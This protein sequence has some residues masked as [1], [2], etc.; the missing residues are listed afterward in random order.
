VPAR[1]MD[2]LFR[3]ILRD[4]RLVVVPA[5]RCNITTKKWAAGYAR[6]LRAGKTTARI[7]PDALQAMLDELQGLRRAALK[8]PLSM[9]LL[10]EQR[11]YA[12]V[13]IALVRDPEWRAAWA[14]LLTQ[15]AHPRAWRC[16]LGGRSALASATMS[17][18]VLAPAE[19]APRSRAAASNGGSA[20]AAT[21]AAAAGGGVVA[22]P[23]AGV[24]AAAAGG[25]GTAAAAGP[26]TEFSLSS[27]P[28]VRCSLDSRLCCFPHAYSPP[29]FV[30]VPG[31]VFLE[32]ALILF[33]TVHSDT[34]IAAK[35]C[36]WDAT[37][38]RKANTLLQTAIGTLT[39]LRDIILREHT[40]FGNDLTSP[41]LTTLLHLLSAQC[42]ECILLETAHLAPSP[43]QPVVG[44]AARARLAAYVSAE[45]EAARMGISD[46]VQPGLCWER[47]WSTIV[48][49]KQIIFSVLAH[50]CQ[51]AHL[52][53][54]HVL[55]GVRAH[56]AAAASKL[57][58]LPSS[59]LPD[60][61]Q[62]IVT[63][64]SSLAR[65]HHS[66]CEREWTAVYSAALTT[67][68]ARYDPVISLYIPVRPNLDEALDLWQQPLRRA[69]SAWARI[70]AF[71][72]RMTLT[73]PAP[74]APAPAVAVAVPS[75][76]PER[77]RPLDD[78][79]AE[80]TT[81]P[82]VDGGVSKRPRPRHQSP[83]AASS[84]PGLVRR[85]AMPRSSAPVS[86]RTPSDARTPSEALDDRLNAIFRQAQ[87]EMGRKI[88]Q[89]TA[90]IL[91]AQQTQLQSY[92]P[93]QQ[94][95]PR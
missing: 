40:G 25:G 28:P 82:A 29:V 34:A 43:E 65:S 12:A 66:E 63:A 21:A 67:Q 54:E 41:V 46:T 62:R 32:M 18:T 81:A 15:G 51:A 35:Q 57:S 53:A 14:S 91:T 47:G 23:D 2:E 19:P 68:D 88:A 69:G 60:E 73:V 49:T 10:D 5:P 59:N 50:L 61:L 11:H 22:A 80:P 9:Q 74:P 56:L 87:D 17:A 39:V 78:T 33:S 76:R 42:A 71:R 55:T 24:T 64:V 52:T 36:L 1:R 45:Y 84:S 37:G 93:R 7:P 4:T 79:P 38:R 75:T 58:E 90:R 77:R 48:H 94:P 44:P 89:T 86:P 13:L 85:E 3:K 92:S 20:S 95:F 26:R 8:T 27:E 31:D 16:A 70:N 30:Q 83:A 6:A 72:A